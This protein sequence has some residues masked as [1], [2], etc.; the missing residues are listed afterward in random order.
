MG[1]VGLSAMA[2]DE[3]AHVVKG[4]ANVRARRLVVVVV[5]VAD[6]ARVT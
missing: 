1:G 3:D 2:T 4:E 5:P 6:G